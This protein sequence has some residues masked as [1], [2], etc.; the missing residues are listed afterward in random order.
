MH[1]AGDAEAGSG[2]EHHRRRSLQHLPSA[3]G[4]ELGRPQIGQ[5][6]GERLEIIDDLN[7]GKI[8]DLAQLGAVDDPG[9]VR[10]R[11]AVMRDGARAR[12]HGAERLDAG[13]A[14]KEGPHGVRRLRMARDSQILDGSRLAADRQGEARMRSSD[15]GEQEFV[16][17]PVHSGQ[18]PSVRIC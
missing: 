8:E 5:R 4:A 11:D 16:R 9:A 18:A 13:M 1:E 17:V 3:D 10:H 7:P 6:P 15:I 14:R 12:Q 2:P